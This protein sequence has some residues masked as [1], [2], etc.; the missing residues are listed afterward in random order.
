MAPRPLTATLSASDIQGP[1]VL[2]LNRNLVALGYNPAGIVVDDVWQAATTAG[3]EQFQASLGETETGILTLGQVVFLPG[4][5]LIGTVDGT[6]GS[7]GGGASSSTG[8]AYDLTGSH[9]EFVGLT[10]TTQTSTTPTTTTPTTPPPTHRWPQAWP[11]GA[12]GREVP[13]PPGR[14]AP[15]GDSAP[16]VS[17]QLPQLPE[18]QLLE[19]QLIPH[20]LAVA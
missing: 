12:Q 15:G 2:E 11:Q 4:A 3:V 5:Q 16:G 1:D 9:T 20:E 13:S 17:A 18:Q 7:T 14:T 10:T 8:T 19:Q 6:V